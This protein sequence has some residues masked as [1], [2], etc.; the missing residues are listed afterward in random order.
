ML[1]ILRHNKRMRPYGTSIQLQKRR[2]Q[3]Q[4]LVE[5]GYTVE[6]VAKQVG[7]RARSIYRWRQ[8]EKHPKKKSKRQPGKPAFLSKAQIKRL[9]KEL[10]RGA[11]AHG[12]MEDYW[13]LDRIGHV[14]WELFKIRYTSSGVWRLMDRVEWSCQRVQRLAIQRKDEAIVSWTRHVWPRIKKV[15]S[16]ERDAGV[17]R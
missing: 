3:A 4:A 14:I 13:T 7:V 11:Y 9:E 2:H 5:E 12:Y 15:A 8:E 1:A 10:L 16:T 17:N 6:Q